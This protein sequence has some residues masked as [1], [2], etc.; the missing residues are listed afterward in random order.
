M[1]GWFRGAP[2]PDSRNE[3]MRLGAPFQGRR[4]DSVEHDVR[5]AERQRLAGRQARQRG[6]RLACGGRRHWRARKVGENRETKAVIVYPWMD[7]DDPR[8]R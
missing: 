3:S 6:L 5:L 8:G 1:G 7:R 2:R 4:R